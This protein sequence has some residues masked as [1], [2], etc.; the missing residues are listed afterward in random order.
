MEVFNPLEDLPEVQ[1]GIYRL[2]GNSLWMIMD[3]PAGPTVR[4]VA[5]ESINEERL[6]TVGW[7]SGERQINEDERIK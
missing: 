5:I 6:V 2:E 4:M 7:A 3:P 1:T